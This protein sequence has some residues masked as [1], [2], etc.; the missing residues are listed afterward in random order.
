VHAR[1]TPPAVVLARVLAPDLAL[2]FALGL[3]PVL[4]PGLALT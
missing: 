1:T 4:A 3:V 2:V